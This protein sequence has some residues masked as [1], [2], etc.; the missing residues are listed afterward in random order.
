[1]QAQFGPLRVIAMD[2]TDEETQRLKEEQHKIKAQEGDHR[3]F[4]QPDIASS[5]SDR[6]SIMSSAEESLDERIQQ[7]QLEQKEEQK[8]EQQA[9]GHALKRAFAKPKAAIKNLMH[10]S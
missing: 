3:I 4:V 5:D 2:C 6:D 10:R 1:M 7:V 9:G 8:E